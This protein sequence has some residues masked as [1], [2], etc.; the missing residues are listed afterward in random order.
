LTPTEGTVNVKMQ[1]VGRFRSKRSCIGLVSPYLQMYDEFS[2]KENLRLALA[3]RGVAASDSP[4][5]EMLE[6]VFLHDRRNDPVR[7]FSSGMKQRMKY[8]FALIHQPPI[9]ILDEPTANLDDE[10]IGMVRQIMKQQLPNG[11]LLVAT[12]DLSDIDTFDMQ[13]DLN[14]KN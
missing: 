4:I 1:S 13:I 10:G 7:T 11:I 5:D 8:A 9:L 3:I 2:A 12:N 6:R 14:V